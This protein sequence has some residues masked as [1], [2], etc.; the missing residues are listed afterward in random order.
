MKRCTWASD[1]AEMLVYHDKEWGIPKKKVSEL[2]ECLTLEIF[3]AGLSWSTVLRKRDAFRKDF[4]HFD[5]AK[6]SQFNDDDIERL[7]NDEAI[8]RNRAKIIATIENA[9]ACMNNDLV[10]L[11]WQPFNFMQMDGLNDNNKNDIKKF[12]N[13]YVKS[14]KDAGFKRVGPTTLYSYFQSVGVINDHELDCFRHDEINNAVG[15]LL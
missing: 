1:S 13:P 3:Q 4:V 2:F 6:I 14:F 5:V 8:I 10:R 11:T 9:K 15:D 12:I 7:M